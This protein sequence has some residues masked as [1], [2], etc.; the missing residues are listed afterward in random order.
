[1]YYEK[2]VVP[3]SNTPPILQ[4]QQ[5]QQ[6]PLRAMSNAFKKGVHYNMKVILRGDVMTGKS[7]LFQRLQGH[8]FKEEYSSTPEIQVMNIPWHYKDTND[9]IKV[10]IWDVIDKA[11]NKHNTSDDIGIKLEH[12]AP[13]Q[14]VIQP[15]QDMGLDAS[16]VNVYRNTHAALFLFDVTKPW[17]FDYVNNELSHVPESLSVLVLGNFADKS[18][19][20]KIELD[21]I[22]ATLYQHNQERMEKGALK[23]NLIRYAETSMKTGL[24]LKYIYEYLGVPFLQLMMEALRKQLELK[25]VEIVDLLETL[26]TDQDVPELMQRRRGQDNFDQPSEPRLA[27]EHAELK[28]AWDQELEE[29]A[30]EHAVLQRDTPPPP[31]SPVK[32]SEKKEIQLPNEA[33]IVV[34]QFDTGEELADD[35]FGEM[36]NDNAIQLPV[37]NI[38]SDQE[39]IPSN[40]MVAGDEDV[41]IDYYSANVVNKQEEEEEEEEQEEN[42]YQ[43]MFKSDIWSQS[44][45]NKPIDIISSDSEDEYPE[46]PSFG[47]AGGYEEIGGTNENPWSTEDHWSE[48]KS[49][50]KKSSSSKKKHKKKKNSLS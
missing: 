5:Q 20:R 36:D 39:D 2:E 22:H 43:P 6:P 17:T 41:Q 25:A 45:N 49:N 11:H 4:Q 15:K 46:P 9:I 7:S 48:E 26:D 33:S 29:I 37:T 14:K 47:F 21:Q 38:E 18:A 32:S 19:E 44:N 27:K 30:A 10:E 24:G 50:V 34:N 23:P 42:R 31:T 12:H 40:P 16:T 3:G 13:Q 8:E 28:A 35:W 1:M